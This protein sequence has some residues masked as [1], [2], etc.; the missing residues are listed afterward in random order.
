MVR[1][2]TTAIAALAAV[3]GLLA[4]IPAARADHDATA[5]FAGAWGL[6]AEGDHG[7]LVLGRVGDAAGRALL[8]A[9]GGAPSCPEPVD[10]YRGRLTTPAGR[11]PV[12]GCS[13]GS[14]AVD[15]LD[16]VYLDEALAPAGPPAELDV[17]IRNLGG[18]PRATL[19]W[20]TPADAGTVRTA[21]LAFLS[22]A[23]GDGAA[24]V[25]TL[26]GL[27]VTAAHSG[28][29]A[30]ATIAGTFRG[31]AVAGRSRY[32]LL[33][34]GGALATYRP[35]AA[36]AQRARIGEIVI[37]ARSGPD[38]L[39]VVGSGSLIGG[40]LATGTG[41][42]CRHVAFR[43]TVRAERGSAA[44]RWACRPRADRSPPALLDVFSRPSDR[45]ASSY[46]LVRRPCSRRAPSAAPLVA[47]AC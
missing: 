43:Y 12:V 3:A 15:R 9:V 21:P 23:A 38:Y 11:G 42:A 27:R 4:P 1:P 39:R 31:A 18:R 33:P 32:R 16:G 10:F 29:G 47:A 13:S 30:T 26:R 28:G 6:G 14:G 8:A 5:P 19:R 36:P 34:V 17:L 20:T 25:V 41:G 40:P 2:T 45:I 22:H 46:T 7:R 24:P 44:L 35:S 37:D